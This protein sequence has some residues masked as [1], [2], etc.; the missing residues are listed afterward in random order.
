MHVSKQFSLRS[1]GEN[2]LRI[3]KQKATEQLYNLTVYCKRAFATKISVKVS[4]VIIS[5][6]KASDLLFL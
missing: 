5:R 6:E 1:V 3:R 2:Y 4:S